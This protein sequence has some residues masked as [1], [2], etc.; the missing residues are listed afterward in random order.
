MKKIISLASALLSVFLTASFFVSCNED[1]ETLKVYT[2]P[3][4]Q[5]RSEPGVYLH[6]DGNYYCAMSYEYGT[7]ASIELRRSNCINDFRITDDKASVISSS[8][9]GASGYAYFFDPE[10]KFI[11]G[12]WYMFYTASV[13]SSSS[14]SQRPFVARCDEEDPVNASAWTVLGEV[15]AVESS[16]FNVY[17]NIIDS[18]SLGTT[19]FEYDGQWYMM[20]SQRIADGSAWDQDEDSS[21]L[22]LEFNGETKVYEDL[23]H[24]A[25]TSYNEANPNTDTNVYW[26]CIF[27]G[28]TSP[29][30]FTQ[31]TDAAI[32][33]VPEYDW[34]CG[35]YSPHS[36]TSF[37][38]TENA[39]Q[40]LI[41]GNDLFIV[42]SASDMDES[43]CM[44]I[45]KCTDKSNLLSISSWNKT[46]SPVFKSDSSYQTYG[47]GSC[48]FTTDD[49]YDVMFYSARLQYGLNLTSTGTTGTDAYADKNRGVYAKA[50]TWKSNG[51]P[52]FGR[53]GGKD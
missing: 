14:W 30:D 19:V 15:K 49:G 18:Y 9:A 21:T 43:Y 53:A 52:D 20:W 2:G 35:I 36:D 47:P 29:D 22:T 39:P 27:I 34:E 1:V 8:T 41:H 40:A 44:G 11:D 10:I 37:G 5:R 28:K 4:V 33:S 16:Q 3:L 45:M 13:S 42:F 38:N 12:S 6:S 26:D 48:S 31:V 24:S 32:I 50:F 17:E 51:Y 7:W 25:L 46:N 23:A